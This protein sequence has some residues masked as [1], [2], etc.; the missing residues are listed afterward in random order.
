MWW[1]SARAAFIGYCEVRGVLDHWNPKPSKKGTGFVQPL[2]PHA[3]WHVDIS[4]VNLCG[5]FYYLCSLLDGCS[6]C[7]VH[8]ALGEAMKEA[9]VEL[10]IQQALEK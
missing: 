3:H 6:R 4:Y 8:W 9:D 7:I 5:T 2:A 1:P 10:I